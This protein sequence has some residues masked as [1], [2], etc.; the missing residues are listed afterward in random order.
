MAYDA[1]L[2]IDG[3]PGEST[4]T[5]H[6]G[7]IEIYSFSWGASQPVTI[8]SGTSGAGGGKVSISDFSFMKR[9]DAASALLFQKCAAGAHITSA[10]LTLRKSGGTALE[11]LVYTLDEVFVTST[12]TSGSSG[13]DD[14]PTESISLAFKSISFVYQSQA[15]DGTSSGTFPAGYS[16][17][18]NT[19]S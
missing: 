3:I 7:E 4:D 19:V 12:Q 13:G 14:A 10:V 9:T 16:I 15:A 5:K 17:V 11:Y 18:T 2:K 6:A 1:F 8:S